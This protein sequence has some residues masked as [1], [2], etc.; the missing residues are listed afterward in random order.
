MH[1]CGHDAHAAM[2]LTLAEY[3]A[4][5]LTEL[6]RNVLFLF[7]PSEETT[8]GAGKLCQT[9]CAGAAPGPP[10]LRSPSVAGAWPPAPSPPAPAL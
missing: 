7:Q 8:G 2:V 10:D 6:P 4:A 3:A 9:G 1:A 5:H